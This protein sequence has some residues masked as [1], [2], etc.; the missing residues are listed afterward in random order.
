MAAEFLT[1]EIWN[2]LKNVKDQFGFTI[3][4]VVNSGVKNPD[5][6]I[7]VYCG[8]KDSYR[9]FAPFLD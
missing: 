9:V 3:D 5:S 4:K 6:N 2:Q 7:G 1:E 8:S